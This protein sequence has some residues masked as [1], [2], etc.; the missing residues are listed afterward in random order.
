[1]VSKFACDNGISIGQVTTNTK[2]NEI[3]AIPK[4]LNGLSIK[5]C[6]VTIVAICC[7]KYFSC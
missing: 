3:V 4:L 1:M 5:G 6:I 2:S 7:Q